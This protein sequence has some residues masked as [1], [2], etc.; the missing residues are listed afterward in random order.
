MSKTKGV[1]NYIIDHKRVIKSKFLFLEELYYESLI[2]LM[3]YL[4]KQKN[5]K[6]N[7]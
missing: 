6:K 7:F 2:K 5:K 1:N 4:K 3:G